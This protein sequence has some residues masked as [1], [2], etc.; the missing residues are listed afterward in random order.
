MIKWSKKAATPY[1]LVLSNEE[2]VGL[3]E[4]VSAE[5]NDRSQADIKPT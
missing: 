2:T 4:N 3:D 1:A 5:A